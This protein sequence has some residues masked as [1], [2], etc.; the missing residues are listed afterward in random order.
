MGS[1]KRRITLRLRLFGIYRGKKSKLK[2]VSIGCL[3]LSE[4][5]LSAICFISELGHQGVVG[6][7]GR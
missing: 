4:K 6:D 3:Q 5:L 7:L 2:G 1:V